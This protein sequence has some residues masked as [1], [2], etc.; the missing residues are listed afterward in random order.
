MDL[1]IIKEYG[2]AVFILVGAA[3][4]LHMLY[5][6]MREDAK[7]SKEDMAKMFADIQQA[8]KDREDRIIEVM[9]EQSDAIK[10]ISESTNANTAELKLVQ[11]ILEELKKEGA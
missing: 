1:A 5:K 10:S 4:G 8:S 9:K 3:K 6:N 7:A 11:R 2:L